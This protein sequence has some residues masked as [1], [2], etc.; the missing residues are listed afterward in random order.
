MLKKILKYTFTTIN[1]TIMV[2]KELKCSYLDIMNK[3]E[4]RKLIRKH[5]QIITINYLKILQLQPCKKVDQYD[6]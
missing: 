6:P 3:L 2:N 1:Y 5:H 4:F